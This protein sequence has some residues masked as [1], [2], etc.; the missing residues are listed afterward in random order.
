M[1]TNFQKRKIIQD[2][3]GGVG[4]EEVEDHTHISHIAALRPS[5]FLM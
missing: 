4:R 1:L 3:Q 5:I 2:D